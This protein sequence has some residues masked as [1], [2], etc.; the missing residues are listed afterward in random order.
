MEDPIQEN[1]RDE[2]IPTEEQ[3]E[4]E[5]TAEK[6]WP[7][8]IYKVAR[9]ERPKFIRMSV[10]FLLIAYIYSVLRDTKDAV[11][12]ERQETA[13]ISF[14][15]TLFVSPFS[16]ACI[17][18]IQ[19]W[20]MVAKVQTILKTTTLIFG[21]YFVIYGLC[22]LPFQE[23]LEPNKFLSIDMFAD[24]RMAIRGLQPMYALLLT[25][26]FY[27]SSLLYITSELWGNI[28][29][30]L[31]FMSFANDVC[32][33]KQSIRFVPLFYI[34]SNVGLML[35][36]ATLLGF[37][38]MAKTLPFFWN[39]FVINCIFCVCGLLCLAIYAIQVNLERT[40]LNKPIFTVQTFVEKKKKVK[41][42][43]GEGLAY[44]AKSKLL[45]Q[46]SFIVLAYNICTNLVDVIC[47][48]A[49]KVYALSKNEPIGSSVMQTQAENQIYVAA[50]VILVLCSPCARSIQIVGWTAVGLATPIWSLV[51]TGLVLSLAVYNTSASN[52]NQLAFINNIWGGNDQLL[53]LEKI[54]GQIA[55]NGLKIFK[56]AFFDLAKEAISMRI[57]KADRP[58]F[59]SVYDGIC[60]KLGKSIGGGTQIALGAL[61]NSNDHRCMAQYFIIIIIVIVLFWFN[62][63]RYL[64]KKY[65]ESIN[66]NCN[67]DVD[68]IGKKPQYTS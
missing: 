52:T 22:V 43:Y 28:I 42:S 26:N 1:R 30:S 32:P 44:M 17:F 56:Y 25:G 58:M 24:G 6:P 19:K 14:L 45:L 54:A 61:S 59:K 11:V 48:S 57:D 47:K 67:I 29:L 40:V 46:I 5:A 23:F 21:V 55:T 7:L 36:G 62:S 66:N 34:A 33:F 8:S 63:V 50:V 51:C 64:G 10:M 60:G 18:A 4:L 3:V 53:K 16:I 27:T 13:S 68:L 49:I 65:N 31:L 37:V 41:L 2:N 39:R 9:C 35:S 12:M 38:K 20:L 15:K